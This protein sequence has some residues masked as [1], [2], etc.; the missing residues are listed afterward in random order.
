MAVFDLVIQEAGCIST[1]PPCLDAVSSTSGG[2]HPKIGQNITTSPLDRHWRRSTS[3]QS[4]IGATPH[5]HSNCVAWF[6]DLREW[7]HIY[8][9]RLSDISITSGGNISIPKLV[10]RSPY[11]HSIG[12]GGGLL[13]TNPR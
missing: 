11:L 5:Y 4:E 6:L 12:T 2:F 9:T 13:S 10:T 3:H 8:F 7:L 1:S